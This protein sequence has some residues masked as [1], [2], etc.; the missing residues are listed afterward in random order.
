[1]KVTYSLFIAFMY[2]LVAWSCE[3][4][5]MK[6][7]SITPKPVSME[8][9]AGC[10]KLSPKTVINV[11]AGAND[12]TAANDF[13]SNLVKSSF[14][15]SLKIEE[16]KTKKN[17]I[18]VTVTS[19]MKPDAY[20]LHVTSKAIDIKA[21]SS[22]G[23]FYAYQSL[24][25]MLPV[26]IEKGEAIKYADIQNVAIQDEPRFAYRG[27]MLD[28]CRHFFTVDEVKTYIDILA[29]HKLNKFHWHL[30]D[31]QAW[32]IEVK[33]YPKLIEIGSYRPETVI[34]KN[35][36]KYDGKPHS[37]FYTQEQIQEVVK[38]AA[39]RYITV[40]PEIELPG[41]ALAALTSYPEL[42]CT[43]GPYEVMKD[44]GI[45]D[46]VYCAGNDKTIEFLKDV[47]D[48]IIPLFPSEYIH[49]GGDE[50]PKTAW[51]QCKKCQSRIKKEGLKDEHELQSYVIQLMEQHLNSK[52]KKLIGWDEILEGGISKTATIMS[53]RGMKGGINAAKMGNNVIMTPNTYAY[54]DYYQSKDVK[55]E[56]FGIGGFVNVAKV[57]SL[58]PTN[59]L[60]PE[61]AKM[62][63]GAQ[64]N[65]WTEYIAQFSHVQ[66]MV[67]PRMA[68]LA[69][70]A[71]TPDEK[72]DYTDFQKRAIEL[73]KRYEAL[74]YNYAKHILNTTSTEE[75]KKDTTSK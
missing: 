65:L 61:E 52:G 73:T 15:T 49:V 26:S 51:K 45:S 57:Y 33:K 14:G 68:A 16:G 8:I 67:L 27:M 36:G 64:A 60:S 19:E 66:Y 28:V 31:D 35:T 50:C 47:F 43:G 53:W 41:H 2:V 38:Y 54:L 5:S 6:A 69:E 75:I 74:G 3:C 56:P 71:W 48:E 72:K 37:G 29:L 40:I 44:W 9:Q 24:R 46:Q 25:Q 13:L 4:K 12:L 59:G 22:R 32:R 23:V 39:D 20:A 55:N 62:V 7:V 70:V 11:V 58:N 30:T 1:M 17:A 42:G 34:G 63:I 18:N 10:F 21:G